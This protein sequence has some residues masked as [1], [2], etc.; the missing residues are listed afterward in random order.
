MVSTVF[1]AALKGLGV[2]SVQVEADISN[3]LPMFHMVGYLASEVKEAGDRVRSAIRNAEFPFPPK[4]VVVNLSPADVRKRG[5]AF[6]LPIAIAILASLEQVKCEKLSETLLIGE[7]GLDGT[8]KKVSGVLPI[9]IAAK[10]RGFRVCI[11]PEENRE[12]GEIIEGIHVIGV[13]HIREACAYLNGETIADRKGKARTLKE[14]SGDPIPD[15]SEIQGQGPLKR[16]VEV[17]V[18]GGHNLLMIGP[19]GVGKTMIARR[20]PTIL[21]PLNM[22]ESVELSSIYSIAG[23]L[24]P[25][26]PLMSLC[27][28]REVHHSITRAALLGG[29]AFP[30]PGEISLANHGVLF[31]D[32]LAEFPKSILELMRQPMDTHKV[33]IVRNRQECE[34]PAEF[35]LVATMN[36]CPCGNYPDRNRCSCTTVQIQNYWNKISSPLLDRIDICAQA[37]HI[38]YQHLQTSEKEE[39]SDAIR[40]RV[41]HARKVQEARY[42]GKKTKTNASLSP[43]DIGIHCKLGKEEQKMMGHVFEKMGL[44]ARAYHKILCVARTIADLDGQEQIAEEHLSE[45]I[46][47]RLPE[48]M[49]RGISYGV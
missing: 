13:G 26:S 19:P 32:E 44:S 42:G 2:E 48:R 14:E 46:S 33:R 29:G 40:E 9:V 37:E 39:T 36:P 41:M 24:N 31:L 22:E 47:Y 30:K 6:D 16:A 1:S 4:K 34:F 17:A 35:L 27:P 28:F 10:Q 15:Y 8:V 18:S 38:S 45:A 25:Q 5:T 21:P 11:V 20:I 43:Q 23:E 12:E 3:G 7:L 49:P